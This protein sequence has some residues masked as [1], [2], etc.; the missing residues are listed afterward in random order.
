MAERRVVVAP[1][2]G[3]HAR[4]A[5][6]FVKAAGATGLSVTIARDGAPAAD[7]RSILSVLSL[8]VRGGE[9]VVLTAE[10]DNA[11]SALDQLSTILTSTDA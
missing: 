9:E 8:D 2:V 5:A 1:G 10:G 6:L 3:L 4:P 7:A 11:E